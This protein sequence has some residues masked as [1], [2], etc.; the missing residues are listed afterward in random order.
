[1]MEM[2]LLLSVLTV[3]IT[4]INLTSGNDFAVSDAS[5]IVVYSLKNDT[6]TRLNG[7]Q[8]SLYQKCTYGRMLDMLLIRM[9]PTF[10]FIQHRLQRES[11]SYSHTVSRKTASKIPSVYHP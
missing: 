3:F 11:I 7:V 10:Y 9:I 5:G 4:E 8:V 1:M 2:Y 6:Q